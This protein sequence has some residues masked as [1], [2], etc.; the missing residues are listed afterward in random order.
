MS[1][2]YP[3]NHRTDGVSLA[4][5]GLFLAFAFQSIPYHF[6]GTSLN[7]FLLL[8]LGHPVG[9]LHLLLLPLEVV[10]LSLLDNFTG[11]ISIHLLVL[12]ICIVEEPEMLNML[13]TTFE[14]DQS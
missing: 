9:D 3:C 12:E 7:L 14:G 13:K 1:I 2:I 4:N 8:H 10:H 5:V 11:A 6:D